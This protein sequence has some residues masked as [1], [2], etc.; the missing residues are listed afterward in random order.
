MELLIWIVVAA[1]MV[2][3]STPITSGGM[4]R[5]NQKEFAKYVTP[6]GLPVPEHVREPLIRR[7]ASRE[8]WASW[9]A[10]AALL[11]AVIV[12]L[13]LGWTESE[14]GVVLMLAVPFGAS[15]G[16]AIAI[17][18]NRREFTPGAP[19]VARSQDAS[20]ADYVTPVRLWIARLS[21][22]A[23]AVAF[24]A[25]MLFLG[26]LPPVVR[27]ATATW[28]FHASWISVL[29]TLISVGVNEWLARRVLDHPQPSE[30]RL[31]LAWDDVCR[32]DTVRALY[33]NSVAFGVLSC[34]ASLLMVGLVSID[35]QVRA[36]AMQL[37]LVLATVMFVLVTILILGLLVPL[38]VDWF[39]GRHPRRHV[40][41]RLWSE[42]DFEVDGRERTC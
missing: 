20:V 29:L 26:M 19:R 8:R 6:A 4:R 14:G 10:L 33:A 36:G 24:G 40:L 2:A 41:Q 27:D 23:A 16:A 11:L 7:I 1:S 42:V 37:T 30:S 34:F 22:V 32:G 39:G 12:C 17:L 3:A 18:V 21:P 28:W 31:E 25:G 5:I 13:V 9:A 38:L 35:P 15:V